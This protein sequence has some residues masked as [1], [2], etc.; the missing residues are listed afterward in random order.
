VSNAVEKASKYTVT[1]VPAIRRKL[2]GVPLNR[3]YFGFRPRQILTAVARASALTASCLVA[4][5][6]LSPSVQAEAP[7]TAISY[8]E[9][10]RYPI[11]GEG[12]WDYLTYDASGSR[13]F[14]TRGSHVMVVSTIT[15]KVTGDITGLTGCHGVALN[16]DMKR[17]YISEG[18]SN[19]VTVFDLQTLKVITTIPV[20]QRPD[21]ILYEPSTHHIFTFNGSSNDTTVVDTATNKVLGTIALGGK[22]EFAVSDRKGKVFVNIED[23]AEVLTLD[24]KKMTVNK[25]TALA[26]AEGPSGLAIDLKTERLYSAGD[27]KLAAVVDG[28]TGK[29]I[30]TPAIGDGPDAATFD[31]DKKRTFFSNGEGTLSILKETAPGKFVSETIPTQKGARTMTI[32]PKAH[33][34]YL[35]AARTEPVPANAPLVNGR[36]PRPKMVPDSFVVIVY[37]ERK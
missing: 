33:R 18:G 3:H 31:P 10:A 17:G 22:P 11:G 25:R 24:P 8:Q 14:I 19:Q 26:P 2:G 32:D 29:L 9:V 13:L 30:A 7:A 20:G 1:E 5:Y 16:P 34:L 35:V 6:G 12:G 15:G 4:G 23:T 28:N 36:A 27:N 21:A 37:G